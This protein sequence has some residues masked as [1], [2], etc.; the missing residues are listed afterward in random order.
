MAKFAVV[1]SNGI[2]KN[3]IKAD[4]GFSVPGATLIDLDGVDPAPLIGW[5][6]DGEL[7]TAPSPVP[8]TN[9]GSRAGAARKRRELRR[10]AKT[11]FERKLINE[12]I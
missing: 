6:Y 12:V 7:F 5:S 11:P 2:V 8:A 4:Q 10:A 3:I 9:D 1:S